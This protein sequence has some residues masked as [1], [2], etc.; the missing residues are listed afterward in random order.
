ML[1]TLSLVLVLS[2]FGKGFSSHD[3][4][5]AIGAYAPFQ[6]FANATPEITESPA[7]AAEPNHRVAI[8]TQSSS[9][10]S[11]DIENK[12]IIVTIGSKETSFPVDS[13]PND[14]PAETAVAFR[15]DENWAVWDYRGLTIRS[16]KTSNST[17]LGDI[18][19]S[20]RA[21]TRDQ[22][23]NNLELFDQKKRNRNA[24]GLSGSVK[25]GSKCYFLPRWTDTGG[26][27]WLEAL[28]EVDLDQEKPKAKFLGR[29]KGFTSAFKPI[30]E[31]MFIINDQVSIVANDGE[32]WGVSSYVDE[33]G[34]FEFSPMG[35]GLVSYYRGGYFIEKT[36][37]GTYI[38]GQIDL[39]SGVRKNLYESRSKS[40]EL[41]D[42]SPILVVR[43][44]TSTIIKNLKTG[45]IV[46][47]QKN[48]YVTSVDKYV[49]VWTYDKKTS[50]WLYDPV[51]W[52]AVRTAPN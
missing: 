21:F 18:A 40:V 41:R 42:G 44:P 28:I 7:G 22:I 2:P 33:S 27:T 34:D 15:K 51:R 5:S 25:I 24:D 11:L 30:D 26:E 52:T 29:F 8:Q 45:S 32:A 13:D 3:M 23:K 6:N 46:T 37:Y 39:L 4:T 49:L 12:K 43:T 31:K 16:G 14:E 38:V 10:L 17:K 50:A 1:T 47:H 9:N 19:V 36:S 20:P 48:A 35:S